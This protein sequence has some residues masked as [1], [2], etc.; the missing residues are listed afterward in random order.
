[1]LRTTVETIVASINIVILEPQDMAARFNRE[2]RKSASCDVPRI[3]ESILNDI[4]NNKSSRLTAIS[5]KRH[6]K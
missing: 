5:Y 2:K 3:V 4:F 1:M 6:F